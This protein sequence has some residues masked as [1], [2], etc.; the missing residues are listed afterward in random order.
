MKR[1]EETLFAQ[2]GEKMLRKIVVLFFIY[3]CAV[4]IGGLTSCLLS[5]PFVYETQATVFRYSF[6]LGIVTC[7]YSILILP[8]II[9]FHWLVYRF[10]PQLYWL[11]VYPVFAYI[12]FGANHFLAGFIF[13]SGNYWPIKI[14]SV[15]MDH[16][17]VLTMAAALSG[18][19]A[20]YA[21]IAAEKIKNYYKKSSS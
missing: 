11:N 21:N 2:N 1:I 6:F 8:V 13:F 4:I 15:N 20:I 18:S 14:G 17:I 10:L 3:L 19:T 9:I 7:L 5:V 12:I 16:F